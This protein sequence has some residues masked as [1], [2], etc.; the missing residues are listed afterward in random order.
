MGALAAAGGLLLPPVA[1]VMIFGAL[2]ARFGEL[3][4][5]QR[6]LVGLAAAAAGL[7]IAAAAK[8]TEPLFRRAAGPAPYVAVAVFAAVG[9]AR[10]PMLWV[11]L[12]ALPLSLALAWWWRR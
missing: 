8:M 3:A 2:Y 7:I 11:L 6:V 4:A 12:G 5:L 9:F 1:V 10:L